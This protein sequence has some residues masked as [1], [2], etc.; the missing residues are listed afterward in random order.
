MFGCGR[1][2]ARSDRQ[3]NTAYGSSPVKA[4]EELIVCAAVYFLQ[5]NNNAC[6]LFDLLLK[7]VKLRR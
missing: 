6:D 4:V 7:T 2:A 5:F 3:L 1:D